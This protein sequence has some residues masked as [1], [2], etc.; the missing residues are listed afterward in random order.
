MLD[1]SPSA[2]SDKA[3]RRP[4]TRSRSRIRQAEPAD[5]EELLDFTRKIVP[6]TRWA[7][8]VIDADKFRRDGAK[9]LATA[10]SQ[11]CVLLWERTD[12]P[13]GER[14]Q[15]LIFGLVQDFFWSSRRQATAVVF[16]ITPNARGGS[17]ALKLLTAFRRWAE[18]RG[19]HEIAVNITSGD[20]AGSTGGMLGRIGFKW[21]GGNY[22]TDIRAMQNG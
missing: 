21:V 3:G 22:V 5:L 19:A 4:S 17:G 15:G 7:N 13:V 9:I 8:D 14:I 10:G 18:N 11:Y 12:L 2:S 6:G 1:A 20:H 16:A